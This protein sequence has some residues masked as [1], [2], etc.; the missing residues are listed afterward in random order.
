MEINSPH[1]PSPRPR[2]QHLSR[3]GR[4]ARAMGEEHRFR[5]TAPGS[6]GTWKMPLRNVDQSG[7]AYIP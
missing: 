3:N 4:H 6:C 1:D 2:C 7:I 5:G